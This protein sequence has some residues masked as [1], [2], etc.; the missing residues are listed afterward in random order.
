MAN[1][2]TCVINHPSLPLFPWS[3][4][5]F[6]QPDQFSTNFKFQIVL[7]VPVYECLKMARNS[8]LCR[9][10]ED[11]TPP[12]SVRRTPFRETMI[13]RFTREIR[14]AISRWQDPFQISCEYRLDNQRHTVHTFTS[15]ISQY[16][17]RVLENSQVGASRGTISPLCLLNTHEILHPTCLNS[18]L[19]PG[20][21]S[22]Q[23][24]ISIWCS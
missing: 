9:C 23:D 11:L 17:S 10:F 3:D 19:T 18:T 16:G 1:R 6:L 12:L 13:R 15:Y 8:V 14:A 20:P 22:N 24:C 7:D 2:H 21:A 5:Y 4:Q